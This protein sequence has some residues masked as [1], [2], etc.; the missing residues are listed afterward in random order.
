MA[1][2][3]V[4][5]LRAE[6]KRAVRYRSGPGQMN[7]VYLGGMAISGIMHCLGTSSSQASRDGK[8]LG[9]LIDEASDK[10]IEEAWVYGGFQ[11]ILNH[12]RKAG[13]K[14]YRYETTAIEID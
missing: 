13:S 6:M 5:E 8:S 4:D 11:W 10:Q 2:T 3:N 12:Y 1:E 14:L 7:T 9:D